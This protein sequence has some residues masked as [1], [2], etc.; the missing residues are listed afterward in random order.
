MA[1]RT[2]PTGR[3]VGLDVDG[4]LG[5]E[6]IYNL[7]DHGYTQCSLIEGD[8]GALAQTSSDPF[9]LVYARFVVEHMDHPIRGL[10]QMYHWVK[11]G[12]HLLIQDHYH[13]SLEPDSP[14]AAIT[15][16]KTTFAAVWEKA[17]REARTGILLPCYFIKAGIGSPDGTDVSGNLLSMRDSAEMGASVYRSLLPLALKSGITTEQRSQWFFD[18]I[19]QE[20]KDDESY[21]LWPLIISAWKQ[22]PRQ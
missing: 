1:D 17:G 22:K 6:A 11:P 15:E 8:L 9:D 5:R 2:G 4:A 7:F 12:G 19:A 14:S 16:L 20:Q 18:Q 13:P 10:Q 21:L 3:I